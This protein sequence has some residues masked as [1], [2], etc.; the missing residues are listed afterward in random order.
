MPL[1]LPPGFQIMA[2]TG[3]AGFALVNGTPTIISWS[4]PNDGLMHRA[5]VFGTMQVTVAETGGTIQQ[6]YTDPGGTAIFTQVI[7]G[8]LA[9]GAAQ[10]TAKLVT[11]QANSL[12]TVKQSAALTAGAATLWAEI[13]GL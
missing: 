2:S 4:V 13:W 5:I 1:F 6:T 3:L 7:A 11:V 9:I 8:G 10:L 12:V